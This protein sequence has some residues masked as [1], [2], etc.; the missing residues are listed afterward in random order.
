MDKKIIALVFGIFFLASA[1]GFVSASKN[2]DINSSAG[3]ILFANGTS[4]NVGIGGMRESYIN[5]IPVFF[6]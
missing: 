3:T 4:G 2:F 6:I 5:K 1:F